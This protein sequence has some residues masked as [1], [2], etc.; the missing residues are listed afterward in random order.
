[1]PVNVNLSPN[2][3]FSFIFRILGC[4][5]YYSYKYPTHNRLLQLLRQGALFQDFAEK[6]T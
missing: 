5:S 6:I 1:M 2:V 4:C 3:T